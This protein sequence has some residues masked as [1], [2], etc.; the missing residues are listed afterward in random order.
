MITIPKIILYLNSY[1]ISAR[2]SPFI[3][4]AKRNDKE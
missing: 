4:P 3:R 2:T 1:A